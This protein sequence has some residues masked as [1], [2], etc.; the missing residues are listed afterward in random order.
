MLVV[1]V[2]TIPSGADEPVELEL[3]RDNNGVP[4]RVSMFQQADGKL[5]YSIGLKAGAYSL[6]GS[7]PSADWQQ[8]VTCTSSSGPG[9]PR[10]RPPSCST[11]ASWSSAPSATPGHRA[12]RSTWSPRHPATR[13]HSR[14]APA[15]SVTAASPSTSPSPTAA[16]PSSPRPS[17]RASPTPRRRR[18]DRLGPAPHHLYQQQARGL[19]RHP[20][21]HRARARRAGEL[22]VRLHRPGPAHARRRDHASGRP[23]TL[24]VQRQL[25]RRRHRASRLTLADADEA[26][27]WDGL[28]EGVPHS[29]SGSI[30][31]ADWQQAVTCT[32]SSGPGATEDPAAIVLDPGEL[33]ACVFTYTGPPRIALDVVTEPPGHP[34]PFEIEHSWLGDGSETFDF[35]LTDSSDP[36]VSDALETG[37]SYAVAGDVPTGWDAPVI[38][39]TSSKPTGFSGTP[40]D[41]VVEHGELVTCSS[42][43][44]R[45]PAGHR[46]TLHEHIDPE[47][48]LRVPASY[49]PDASRS[50]TAASTF[51]PA[52]ARQVRRRADVPSGWNPGRGHLQRWQRPHVDRPRRWRPRDLHLPELV[53]HFV[54]RDGCAVRQ[55]TGGVRVQ[56]GLRR[57]RVRG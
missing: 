53:S 55:R 29:L 19:Q 38:T 44:G 50:S 42:P 37:M 5:P 16:S 47:C 1:D 49:P 3:T 41:I 4:E 48:E 20:G 23:R 57:V 46:Q 9:P 52:G 45:R 11:P 32:S 7:L 10:T 26:L 34:Q 31:S 54:R 6:S 43:T 39:C 8:D 25:A 12:S 35:T 56:G 30:P 17:R 2:R 13:S 24:R 40:A 28:A 27:V 22:H 15:G 51:R 21:R 36:E 14:S 18:A 33:V